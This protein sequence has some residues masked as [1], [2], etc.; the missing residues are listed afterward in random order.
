M[1]LRLLLLLFLLALFG[2]M[3]QHLSCQVSQQG[4]NKA[5]VHLG[6]QW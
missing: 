1:L 5:R 2:C 4:A 3:G 6:R